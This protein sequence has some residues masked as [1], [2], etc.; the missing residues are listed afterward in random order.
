LLTTHYIEEAE[1]LC[2]RVAIVDHGKVIVQ[3]TP[4]ELKQ[5]SRTRRASKY[6]WLGKNLKKD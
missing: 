2:D 1:R 3:G 5:S 6:V 4:R